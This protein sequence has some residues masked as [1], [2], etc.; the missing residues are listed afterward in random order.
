VN[1]VDD[2]FPACQWRITKELRHVRIAVGGDVADGGAFCDDQAD[3]GGG[4]TTVVL[5]DFRVRYTARGKRTGH[6]R[7]DHTGRQFEGTE[8][9]RF[10]QGLNG[11]RR[12][13]QR[14][15][16]DGDNMEDEAFEQ[17]Y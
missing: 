10:E 1:G 16:Y 5:D 13:P 8:V 15:L 7:H 14:R 3:T 2:F 17:H 4:A 6:W 11:H 12:A 9:E